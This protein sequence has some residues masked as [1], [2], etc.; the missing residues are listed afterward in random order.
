MFLLTGTAFLLD[1][2]DSFAA[3][4]ARNRHAGCTAPALASSWWRTTE[5]F[6]GL[7]QSRTCCGGSPW[8]SQNGSPRGTSEGGWMECSKKCGRGL[9]K[10]SCRYCIGARIC[11]IEDSD[12]PKWILD[13]ATDDVGVVARITSHNSL[14][15]K[16]R[17]Q[18]FSS[19]TASV[20][21]TSTTV[22][23]FLLLP[24]NPPS[25]FSVDIMAL[26][27]EERQRY[28]RELAEY[29][30]RQFAAARRT[31]DN[32]KA[33]AAKLPALHASRDGTM[34]GRKG[35]PQ[36]LPAQQKSVPT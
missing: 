34:A 3:T 14:P 20:F 29:T 4:T 2:A 36:Q 28:S 23:C 27:A 24:T 21:L 19:C 33:A 8:R 26:T 12:V 7:L 30:M 17:P 9:P 25:Y 13:A 16:Y 11:S 32:H 5:F 15:I 35:H 6:W 10:S 1:S 31:L 18:F 22:R